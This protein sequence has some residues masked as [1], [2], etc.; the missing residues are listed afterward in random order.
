MNQL[1]QWIEDAAEEVRRV[2][3][4]ARPRDIGVTRSRNSARLAFA[5]AFAVVIAIGIVP[6][7]TRGTDR[8]PMGSPG[9]VPSTVATVPTPTTSPAPELDCSAAGM[10]QAQPQPDLPEVV[11]AMRADIV[12]AATSCD[13]DAL[14]SLAGTHLVTNFGGGGFESFNEWRDQGD[15]MLD[16]MVSLLSMPH[17]LQ[18]IEGQPDIYA[19]PAA[20]TYDSWDEI[21]A[22]QMEALEEIYAAEELT[23]SREFFDGYALWR[24]GITEDGDWK[25]FLAGD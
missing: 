20:F 4:H 7:L 8:V 2:S 21:P 1:E 19:W 6:F 13:Y 17:G 23:Q 11:A 18:V 24:L 3:R 14:E 10:A 12:R 5:T 9:T 15:D 25:F 22:D 16:L